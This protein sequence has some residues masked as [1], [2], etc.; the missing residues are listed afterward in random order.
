[1]GSAQSLPELLPLLFRSGGSGEQ[2]L[3]K[4]QDDLFRL[5]RP[6]GRSNDRSPA[7][8][9]VFL[10]VEEYV[11]IDLLDPSKRFGV[12]HG[13][14]LSS[15]PGITGAAD[16]GRSIYRSVTSGGSFGANPLSQLIGLGK[17]ERITA[18]EIHWPTSG[19][20][21]HF[22]DVRLDTAFS[23]TEGSD[24]LGTAPADDGK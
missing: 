14:P 19:T 5:S 8:V 23:I 4:G 3:A 11:R 21:Q 12:R 10:L 17:C 16:Q 24:E 22:G 6:L 2:A 1:M 18:L 7:V 15:T 9:E 13:L 20:V